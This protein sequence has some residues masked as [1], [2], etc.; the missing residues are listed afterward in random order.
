MNKKTYDSYKKFV[1]NL[2]VIPSIVCV[3]PIPLD[4]LFGNMPASRLHA[5]CFVFPIAGIIMIVDYV[6]TY[7]RM[8]NEQKFQHSTSRFY[9]GLI[10]LIVAVLAITVWSIADGIL[11]VSTLIRGLSS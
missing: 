11:F 7:F 4:Y 8:V 5:A 9:K 3:L 6:K 1:I 10:P 2:V